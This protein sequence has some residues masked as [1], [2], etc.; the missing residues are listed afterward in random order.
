M[1]DP[2]DEDDEYNDDDYN[3]DYSD[4]PYSPYK[5]Y[6]KF[7]MG[8]T[9]L[10]EWIKNMINDIIDP[11]QSQTKP[12]DTWGII[13]YVPGFPIQKFP[14]SSWNPNT[15]NNKFQYLGSNYAQEHVWKSK[16]W[17]SNPIDQKYKAHLQANALHFIKQPVYYKGLFDILN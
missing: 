13:G 16:Y 17:I 9:P 12:D 2:Y 6:F 1:N 15:A 7:D 4:D 8:N 10:S 14:V 3:Y 5:F 11:N